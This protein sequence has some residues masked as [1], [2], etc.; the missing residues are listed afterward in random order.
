MEI[1]NRS[2]FVR[3]REAADHAA[4]PDDDSFKVFADL[5]AGQQTC[6]FQE[7]WR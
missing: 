4:V 3:Q 2:V 5:G 1:P 6:S 7:T